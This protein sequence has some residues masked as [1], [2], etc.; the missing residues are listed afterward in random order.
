MLSNRWGS[1]H[2]GKTKY[3]EGGYHELLITAGFLEGKDWW[4]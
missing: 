4:K 3:R 2:E 1:M